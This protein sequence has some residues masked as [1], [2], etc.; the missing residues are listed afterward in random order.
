MQRTRQHLSVIFS[1][2]LALA[3]LLLVFAAFLFL[4]KLGTPYPNGYAG[5]YTLMAERIV[6][7]GSAV[8]PTIPLYGPGGIPFAYPPLAFYLMAAVTTFFKVQPFDYLRF[9]PA[10][11]YLLSLVP[12]Y[13]L[14]RAITASPRQAAGHVSDG[15]L[16]RD[17]RLPLWS[18]WHG[19]RARPGPI[20]LWALGPGLPGLSNR[21]L[22]IRR[23]R[24]PF[25]W[26]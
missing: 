25:S 12:M 8:P 18:G 20:M 10:L 6:A 19:P 23:A 3:I 11:F 1:D 15:H 21:Q 9:A 5:L 2:H 4:S 7:N 14:S 24:R 16:G 22:E 26:G 17:D 13:A